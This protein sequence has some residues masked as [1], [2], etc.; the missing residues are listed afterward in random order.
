ML[1]LVNISPD[2]WTARCVNAR[3]L[4]RHLSLGISLLSNVM[5]SSHLC[6]PQKHIPQEAPTLT[7]VLLMLEKPLK[8]EF[9][10]NAHHLNR[11]LSIRLSVFLL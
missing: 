8:T 5:D 6:S 4:F 10:Q 3:P 11:R 9:T 7:Q 1:V 2:F